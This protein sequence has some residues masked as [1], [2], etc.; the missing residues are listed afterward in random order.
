MSFNLLLAAVI[1]LSFLLPIVA[2]YS[3]IKGYNVKAEKL[4]EKP[5]KALPERKTPPPKGDPKWEQLLANIDAY[6]G[7]GK[8]QIPIN[9]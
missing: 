6:D 2:I 3:F 7:T 9:D 8:G 5:I 4:A 1:I